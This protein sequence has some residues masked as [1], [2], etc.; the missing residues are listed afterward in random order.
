M[1]R[2]RVSVAVPI[3]TSIEIVII[4]NTEVPA[5]IW[6]KVPIGMEASPG[7]SVEAPSAANVEI[8]L[9]HWRQAPGR[10]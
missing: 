3:L 2:P 5:P 8:L 6:A 7:G 4:E 10:H 9:C 1:R